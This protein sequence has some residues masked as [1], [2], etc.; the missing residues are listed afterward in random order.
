[1]AHNFYIKLHYYSFFFYLFIFF[2]TCVLFLHVCIHTENF[3][4]IN[5]D[6][7]LYTALVCKTFFISWHRLSP[8]YFLCLKFTFMYENTPQIFIWDFLEIRVEMSLSAGFLYIQYLSLQ[9]TLNL[10]L[11][12][13]NILTYCWTW[14]NVIYFFYVCL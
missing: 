2:I 1:M 14:K 11:K 3:F 13:T 6:F 5:T 7:Q 12:L 4:W 10:K 8:W 9:C